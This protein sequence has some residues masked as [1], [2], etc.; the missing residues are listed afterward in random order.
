MKKSIF[1]GSLS[2]L[3]IFP[4]L[5]DFTTRSFKME[6]SYFVIRS[7]NFSSPSFLFTTALNF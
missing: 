1:N 2:I 5:G 4:A 6:C 3:N 7:F